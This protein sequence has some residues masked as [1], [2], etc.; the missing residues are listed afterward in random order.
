MPD[1]GGILDGLSKFI[2]TAAAALGL[3]LS[4]DG[5]RDRDAEVIVNNRLPNGKTVGDA[6][7]NEVIPV[8]RETGNRITTIAELIDP[9][10]GLAA[11]IMGKMAGTRNN[12]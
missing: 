7:K 3:S 2:R 5:E 6:M 10:G 1:G 11:T 12:Q 4:P 9:T 8:L